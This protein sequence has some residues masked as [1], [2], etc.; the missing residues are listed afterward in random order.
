MASD[1]LRIPCAKGAV[2][3]LRAMSTADLTAAADVVELA[4]TVVRAGAQTL[5]KGGGPDVDQVLGYDLAHAGAAVETAAAMLEYG[6]KGDLEAS[7]TC[8]FV[9]DAVGELAARLF[10][11]EDVWGVDAGAL[12]G[13]RSFCATYRAP[14]F[15]AGLAGQDGPR[16]L[17]DD[18]ELVQ[19]T[20]RRFADEKLA[21]IAE[22]IHRAQRATSP[23]TSSAGW[24]RWAP[25]ACRSPRSTAATGAAASPSTS[26]WSW[27]PRSCPAARWAPAGR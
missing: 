8:A 26:G 27:P 4:R 19:D 6:A 13:A 10:G 15:L 18:F 21:P 22:H 17:D 25:S 23:R 1:R 11:R 3:N 20:F 14:E 16:H 5:A 2:T 12:D 9:A 24:P 7:I